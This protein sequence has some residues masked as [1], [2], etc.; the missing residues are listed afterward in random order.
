MWRDWIHIWYDSLFGQRQ[1]VNCTTPDSNSCDSIRTNKENIRAWPQTV[2]GQLNFLPRLIQCLGHEANLCC[3]TVKPNRKG[4][5]QDLGPWK[6]VKPGNFQVW[7]GGNLT[8]IL[9]R[10]KYDTHMLA[11]IHDALAEANFC[12]SNKKAIKPQTVADSNRHMRYVDKEDRMANSYSNCCTWK[13]IQKLFFHLLNLVILISYILLLLSSCGCKKILHTDFWWTI[14]RNLVAQAGQERN[15][16][17]PIGQAAEVLRHKIS[18]SKHWLI[19]SATHRRC[20]VC[21]AKGV[22]RKVS[23][24]C[25]RC[26]VAPCVDRKCFLDYHTRANPWHFSGCSTGP[27]YTKLGLQ[28]EM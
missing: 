7:T 18:A 28:L 22:N 26:D 16:Q 12:N 5:P 8:E 11:N 4:M 10:D 14:V 13:W 24:K 23:V 6:L 20:H 17:R 15:V 9:W 25:L 21:S 19:L 1:T 3:G 27:T 2:H